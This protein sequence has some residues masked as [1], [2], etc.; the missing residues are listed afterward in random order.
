VRKHQQQTR[1][2]QLRQNYER[3]KDAETTGLATKQKRVCK[4][5]KKKMYVCGKTKKYF[6]KKKN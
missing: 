3:R 6:N 2:T 4:T 5:L 1:T